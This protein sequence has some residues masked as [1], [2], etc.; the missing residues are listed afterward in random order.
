MLLS[1]RFEQALL[2]TAIVHAGQQRKSSE[3]PYL[4]HLLAVTALA[5]E[6]GAN[7][8]EAIGALL[9]DAAEDAG[10][11][12]RLADIR[13]RFGE[14]VAEIVDSCT[15]TY[16]TPKPSWRERKEKYIAHLPQSSRSALLVSCCDK[17]H[18]SRSIVADLRETGAETWKRFKGGRD[19]SLWY[20]RTLADFF[21]QSELPCG[22]IDE[23][24]RTVEAMEA[25]AAA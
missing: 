7:E 8:D 19:G 17:L 12:E 23:L 10:G 24:R 9:H 18:N 21:A 2:Y 16:E 1:P 25:L 22:L 14:A 6:H 13:L 15:D 11:H 5:L 4:A 3:V 20:Y